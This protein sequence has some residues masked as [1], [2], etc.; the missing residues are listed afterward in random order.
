[1]G[2]VTPPAFAFVLV[3]DPDDDEP[4][5]AQSTAANT[6]TTSSAMTVAGAR[7]VRIVSA[8][9]ALCSGLMVGDTVPSALQG[10][11]L[12][13]LQALGAR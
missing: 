10:V 5:Q 9:G 11:G 6:T 12:C 3:D 7:C 4:P 1:V 8:A 2:G 13:G